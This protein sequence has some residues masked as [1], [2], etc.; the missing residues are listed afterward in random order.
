M[1]PE[2]MPRVLLL[3]HYFHPDDVISA[4]LYKDLAVGLADRGWNVTVIPCGR[5]YQNESTTLPLKET[6]N[7]IKVRR[8]WRPPLRQG[9]TIGRI[10]NAIW[11][12]GAWSVL[13]LIY[14]PDALV[15][16]TDPIFSVLVALPWRLFHPRLRILHWCFDL[17]P[18]AATSAGLVSQDGLFLRGLRPLLQR[19][20]RCCDVIGSLG[21][22]MTRRLRVH[23]SEL[24][25]AELTPWA[26]VEPSEPL[27]PDPPER[28]RLFGEA[29]LTLLYSGTFGRAHACDQLIA[30]ARSVRGR[31]IAFAFSVRGHRVEE[32]KTSVNAEDTNIAFTDFAPL[33]Q[34]EQHLSA[35]D[36]LVV[37]LRNE[38]A[39][40]VVPSKFQGALAMGR[41]VLFS[42]DPDSAIGHWIQEHGLGWCLTRDNLHQVAEELIQLESD[43]ARLLALQEHCFRVYQRHFSRE[44]VLSRT[45][46]LLLKF[47]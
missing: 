43:P 2:A 17:Y 19:A 21:V 6:W 36:I 27:A 25:I 22:C 45:H 18:E 28:R 5:S 42:G 23:G 47:Q 35:A 15:I 46:Q 39:G 9:S 44:E 26:L 13:S 30:L 24:N 41:P 38:Y 14:R 12:L 37:S 16:G 33:E 31:D 8:I 4:Q 10:L 1:Y 11:M 29:R 40:T 34:L 3:H 32:L 20:Y 7:G